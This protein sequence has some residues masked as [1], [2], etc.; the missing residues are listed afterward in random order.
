VEPRGLGELRAEDL[1]AATPSTERR[2]VERKKKKRRNGRRRGT[3]STFEIKA[4]RS[5]T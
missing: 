1:R 4:A 5:S 2:G 3:A